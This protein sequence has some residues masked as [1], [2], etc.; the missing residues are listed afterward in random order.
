MQDYTK[1]NDSIFPLSN[2]LTDK[3][4]SIELDVMCMIGELLERSECNLNLI[5]FQ[6]FSFKLL[7]IP[8]HKK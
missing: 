1:F 3:T 2:L 4:L 6:L 8:S 5:H 7:K